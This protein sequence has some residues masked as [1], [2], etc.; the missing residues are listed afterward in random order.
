MRTTFNTLLCSTL[1][2]ACTNTPHTQPDKPTTDISHFN[3]TQKTC[4]LYVAIHSAALGPVPFGRDIDDGMV[5]WNTCA[6]GGMVACVK[7]PTGNG[8][9]LLTGIP[10]HH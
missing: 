8:D 7:T 5:R 4:A 3:L 1:L 9:S 10:W 2:C 6:G